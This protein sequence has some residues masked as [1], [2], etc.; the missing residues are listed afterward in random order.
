MLDW[1]QPCEI[2]ELKAGVHFFAVYGDNFFRSASYIMEALCTSSFAKEKDELRAVEA[3][4]L[5]KR[6]ELSKFGSEY[7]EVLAQFRAM[8]SRF[9]QEMLVIDGLLK[10]RNEAHASYS[11]AQQMK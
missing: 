6:I 5:S 9:E 11:V 4:I 7:R 10:Q 8:T 2:T 3:Q 1:F